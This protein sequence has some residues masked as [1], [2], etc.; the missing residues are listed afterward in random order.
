M[1]AFHPAR[2]CRWGSANIK[3]ADS[4]YNRGTSGGQVTPRSKTLKNFILLETLDLFGR[5]SE[6]SEKLGRVLTIS[7]NIA[8]AIGG[9][10]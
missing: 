2:L 3:P 4:R 9:S 10:S 7:R 1:K 5:I 8:D 6:S